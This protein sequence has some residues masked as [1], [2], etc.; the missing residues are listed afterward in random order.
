MALNAMTKP[1]NTAPTDA[2]RAEQ[3]RPFSQMPIARADQRKHISCKGLKAALPDLRSHER[4]KL[5]MMHF[6]PIAKATEPSHPIGQ[7]RNVLH[8]AREFR[9]VHLLDSSLY[10][11]FANARPPS[12]RFEST[13]RAN[14]KR[15]P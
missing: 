15:R 1:K 12:S 13:R 14:P 8:R 11:N 5:A 7:R 6:H 3:S 9:L 10:G 4:D 2:L